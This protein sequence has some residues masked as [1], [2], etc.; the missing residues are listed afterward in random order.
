MFITL[1]DN[2]IDGRCLP[3]NSRAYDLHESRNDHPKV[4][5]TLDAAVVHVSSPAISISNT[6]PEGS[7]DSSPN[8]P[9]RT[10]WLSD[11]SPRCFGSFFAFAANTSSV[12][13]RVRRCFDSSSGNCVDVELL[14]KPLVRMDCACWVSF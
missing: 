10:R 8:E 13:M 1:G 9:L 11:V 7:D 4:N 6:E 12:A 5:C 14:Y 2:C 3:E